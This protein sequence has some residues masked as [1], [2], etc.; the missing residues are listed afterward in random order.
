MSRRR[1]PRPVG[2]RLRRLL[3]I[4]PWLMEQRVATL[5]EMAERFQLTEADLV[6]DLE[7]AAMCGL[8]PFID[9]M[10]DLF[11]DDDGNVEVGVPRFFLAP[12]QLTAPEGFALLAAGRLAMALPG[13][14]PAGPLGRAL[15]KL[16][17]LLGS[18]EMV[19]ELPQ[20]PATADLVAAVERHERVRLSYW[21]ASSDAIT[22]RVVLPLLVFS[23][24]DHWY[25]VGDDERSGEERTFRIDRVEAWAF[26]GEIVAPA[27]ERVVVPPQPDA[28]FVDQRDLP[29]A[30]LRLS[31]AGR[32]AVER[33][34]V[35]SERTDGTD[36]LVEV[37]VASERWLAELLLRLGS[38][39]VVE[40]PAE[41]ADL[42]ARH[43]RALLDARY[44]ST[45]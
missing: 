43:A 7:Q 26:T 11:I 8:P 32:W 3:V 6:R 4:L 24:R 28:W 21:S 39:A 34:P 36:T 31:A 38:A 14:D 19:I 1:G 13:F 25:L 22:D 27:S 23:D 12:L 5:A 29:T 35:R 9:E 15:V 37:V 44:V 33:L 42:G 41:W 10:I 17:A 2:E 40:S 20:P 16:E 45:N 18:D 30:T